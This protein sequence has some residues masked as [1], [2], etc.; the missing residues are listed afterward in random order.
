MSYN[1]HNSNFNH[2]R[3][4]HLLRA[5]IF[6]QQGKRRKLFTFSKVIKRDE[7]VS[8][9]LSLLLFSSAE[10][11]A[12]TV[13][14]KFAVR[15]QVLCIPVWHTKGTMCWK[16]TNQFSS[17]NIYQGEWGW[18]SF[19]S[20]SLWFTDPTGHTLSKVPTHSTVDF[21]AW[22]QSMASQLESIP[23]TVNNILV[24]CANIVF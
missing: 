16:N 4:E 21:G 5:W 23:P 24:F 1:R 22:P 14:I 9:Q 18:H 11:S 10:S 19:L 8:K 12:S 20:P 13:G 17:A 7:T 3:S 15:E 6:K 2:Y